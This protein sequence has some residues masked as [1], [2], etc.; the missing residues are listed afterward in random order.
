M[1]S[2]PHPHPD[3]DSYYHDEILVPMIGLCALRHVS[4]KTVVRLVLE[5]N[6]DTRITYDDMHLLWNAI[7]HNC[8]H[9]VCFCKREAK[10]MVKV[11]VPFAEIQVKA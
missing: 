2:C 6:Q 11:C 7:V 1:K 3:V 5:A 4:Y 8:Y 9:F 10:A